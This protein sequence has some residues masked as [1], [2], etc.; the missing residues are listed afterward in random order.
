MRRGYLWLAL[1]IGA[2]FAVQADEVLLYRYVDNKGVT[3][4]DRQGVPPEYIGKGYQVLNQRGRVIQ[5]V[6]PALT[7]EQIQQKQAEKAQADAN[8]QLLQ[9]YSSVDEVDKAQGRKL[10]E[11]DGLIASVQT[12]LQALL[13]QQAALQGQAAEQERA[14]KEVSP[15]LLAQLAGLRD[16]QVRMKADIDKYRAARVQSQQDFAVDRARVEQLLR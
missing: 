3:V 7:A 14:G 11:L 6:A 16:E 2:S 12:N 9:R 13:A 5:T 10:A 4:L 1:A 15:Q 8:A